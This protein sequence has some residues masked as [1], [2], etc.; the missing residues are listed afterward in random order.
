M[1]IGG[2]SW[3]TDEGICSVTLELFVH[4]NLSWCIE[5]LK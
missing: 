5:L 2:L 4:M 3:E 1:F